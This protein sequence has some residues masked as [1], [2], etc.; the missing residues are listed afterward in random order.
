MMKKNECRAG[1]A[2][3]RVAANLFRWTKRRSPTMVHDAAQLVSCSNTPSKMGPL[4]SRLSEAHVT[5]RGPCVRLLLLVQ[6]HSAG[7]PTDFRRRR[8]SLFLSVRE[9]TRGNDRR[10]AGSDSMTAENLRPMIPRT[11][12]FPVSFI[13]I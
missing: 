9:E 5:G 6:C 8:S 1:V 10:P 12:D 3:C 13:S 7:L 11:F 4:S 2:T